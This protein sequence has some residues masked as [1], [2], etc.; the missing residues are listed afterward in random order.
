M[1]A[2]APAFRAWFLLLAA[3]TALLLSAC[4]SEEG[5]AD[6]SSGYLVTVAAGGL[7]GPGLVLQLNGA[8]DLAFA[9]DGRQEFS[10]RLR[11]GESYVVSIRTQPA[12]VRCTVG[13]ASGQIRGAD[14]YNVIVQCVA[15]IRVLAGLPGGAGNLDLVGANARF[16]LPSGVAFDAAGVM[17]IADTGNHT[18]RRVSAAGEVTTLAGLSGE[19]GAVDANGAAARFTEPY[20]IAVNAAGHVFVADMGN[21][22]IR[23][24]TPDG[25]VTTFAG[26]NG[27]RGDIDG[28][29]AAARFSRP[30]GLTV[31][32]AGTIY[33]ADQSNHSIRKITPAGVVSTFAGSNGTGSQDGPGAQASFW[34]PSDVDVD[35]QG[36]VYVADS[37]NGR[38]R[39]IAPDGTVSSYGPSTQQGPCLRMRTTPFCGPT[40]IAVDDSGRV[41]LTE[42]GSHSIRVIEP[43]G[44]TVFVAGGTQGS[45]D[46]T[47]SQAQF[48]NPSGIEI[49]PQGFAIVA[50]T[51]NH[52]IRRV[53]LAGVVTSAVGS[54]AHHGSVDG[55]GRAAR[56]NYPGGLAADDSGNLFVSD[57]NNNTL[58]RI[59]LQTAQVSTVAGQAG[60]SGSVDGIGLAARFEGPTGLASDGAGGYFVADSGNS[61]I[62][63]IDAAGRVTTFAGSPNMWANVDGT[64]SAA[65]FMHPHGL[66]RDSSG[67]L[68]VSDSFANTIRR[69]TPAGAVTTLAGLSEVAGSDDG[70]GS[71]ARFDFP[72]GLDVDAAGNVYVADSHNHTIRTISPNGVVTT[73]AGSAG[74]SGFADGIAA[75]FNSP[76]SVA[77]SDSGDVCVGDAN[78]SLRRITPAGVVSTLAGA[79]PLEGLIEGE[80]PG[81][82]G[83]PV[84]IAVLPGSPLRLAVGDASEQVVLL[85]TP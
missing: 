57:A 62:R 70:V 76:L 9:A 31:D 60:V 19:S 75:L 49:D 45:N 61:T 37:Q 17:Y 85:I 26:S 69:I 56:F 71:L 78:P 20:G 7:P 18:I 83:A 38:V 63:H 68:Y 11:E 84:A 42:I 54:P 13:N 8:N 30:T 59:V 29:G 10:L 32:S 52:G 58:R 77:V 80:L 21:S 2:S 82:L 81:S 39:R 74:Q 66:A 41:W 79:P 36:I 33:V 72:R 12:A 55:V 27:I 51:T 46:G 64:G 25:E 14:V 40:G 48:F 3:A 67:N 4:G 73:F 23:R 53:S 34:F 6:R 15:P 16:R 1:D 43:S 50:D 28:S 5:P 22:S 44:E 65:R 47:G 24:I 35:S